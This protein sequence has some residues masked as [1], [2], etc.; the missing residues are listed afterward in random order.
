MAKLNAKARA[1]V[2]NKNY[3][4]TIDGKKAYPMPDA[5][6]VRSAIAMFGHCPAD[7]KEALARN[8][9]RRIKE[10]GLHIEVSPGSAFYDYAGQ[11]KK[12]KSKE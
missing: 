2:A 9:K 6:H 8:I 5:S 12:K 10:L 3:G 11:Y 1:H 4:A 7:K